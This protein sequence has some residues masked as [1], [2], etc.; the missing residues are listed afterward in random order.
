MEIRFDAVEKVFLRL[1]GTN[2]ALPPF[3]IG[4]LLLDTIPTVDKLKGGLGVLSGLEVVHTV[5]ENS[6]APERSIEVAVWMNEEGARFAAAMM[7][8]RV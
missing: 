8:S 1:S 4:S 7:G 2:P 3:V 6:I 5:L